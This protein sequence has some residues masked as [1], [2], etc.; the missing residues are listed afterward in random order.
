[1]AI[2]RG[3]VKELPIFARDGKKEKRS[4]IRTEIF[5]GSTCPGT[6]R[7]FSLV[8]VRYIGT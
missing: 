2:R 4:G 1:M 8:V 5:T 7:L 6:G 3:G